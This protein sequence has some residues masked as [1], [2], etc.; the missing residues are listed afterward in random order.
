M[1]SKIFLENNNNVKTTHDT[2]NSENHS[3]PEKNKTNRVDI[4]VL[5]SKLEAEE[6]RE[7]K[8]NLLI[9]SLCALLLGTLGV[10]L[11]L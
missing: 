8:K 3:I 4:N 1:S 7:F 2:I 6:S 10:Y 9:F 5:K 11:S